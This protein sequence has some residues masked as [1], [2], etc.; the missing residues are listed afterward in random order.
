MDF[1]QEPG[2]D[3]Y[4][5][6]TAGDGGAVLAPPA[7]ASVAAAAPAPAPVAAPVAVASTPAPAPAADPIPRV[8][9]SRGAEK[10]IAD[11][12]TMSLVELL[13]PSRLTDYLTR[14]VGEYQAVV[15]VD[16]A[17][18]Q[19]IKAMMR[20]ALLLVLANQKIAGKSVG[21]A[22][23]LEAL[24]PKLEAYLF[25]GEGSVVGRLQKVVGTIVPAAR[26][27]LE[28]I[29]EEVDRFVFKLVKAHVDSAV[30]GH[31]LTE[32][33]RDA[34]RLTG[35]RD[36]ARAGEKAA[37]DRLA[38][39]KELAAEQLA[40]AKKAGSRLAWMAGGLGTVTGALM[41]FAVVHFAR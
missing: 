16:A 32:R 18:G 31:E 19:A 40:D 41:A 1:D 5:D 36:A 3:D 10:A 29:L 22:G 24:E 11:I 6:P 12:D 23:Q 35:E 9:L 37:V 7:S 38:E 20:Q 15:D 33:R 14:T 21:V 17:P 27:V 4:D 13:E 30:D 2:T 34:E 25:G 26:T 8:E 39:F 28:G